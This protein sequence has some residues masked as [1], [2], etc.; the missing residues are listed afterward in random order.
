[1]VQIGVPST[2]SLKTEHRSYTVSIEKEAY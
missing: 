1:M 2:L